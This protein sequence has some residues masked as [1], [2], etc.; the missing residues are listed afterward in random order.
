MSTRKKRSN[1]K[2]KS[3]A[4]TAVMDSDSQASTGT[5]VAEPST[6]GGDGEVIDS[7]TAADTFAKPPAAE[8]KE[9]A[10]SFVARVGQ[11]QQYN[12][13]DPFCI[14]TDVQLGVRLLESRQDRQVAIKFGEGQPEDKPSQDIIA[15]LKDAGFRWNPYDK[16]WAH[17]VRANDAMSIR[18]E[19]ERL[20][21]D[22]CKMIR[23]EKGIAAGTE[24]PF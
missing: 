11:K 23:Q 8:D 18:I 2:S 9:H 1:S 5:A 10:P 17:P 13:P 6:A 15:T 19:A 14:A 16:I 20:Y 7:Q 3:A 12:I 24:V 4:D 22:V 21:Q